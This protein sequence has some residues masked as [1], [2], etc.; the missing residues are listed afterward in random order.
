MDAHWGAVEIRLLGEVGAPGELLSHVY[1]A[2]ARHKETL[3]LS[4]LTCVTGTHHYLPSED[5]EDPESV[6]L[7]LEHASQSQQG[8]TP[9]PELPIQGVWLGGL[10]VTCSQVMLRVQGPHLENHCSAESTLRCLWQKLKTRQLRLRC[11]A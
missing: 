2:H 10:R 11:K 5:A 6:V 8:W 9:P 3:A 4:S 1:G 7:T